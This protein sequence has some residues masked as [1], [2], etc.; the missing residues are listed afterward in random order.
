MHLQRGFR[1]DGDVAFVTLE[2]SSEMDQTF[3]IVEISLGIE[4]IMTNIT[5]KL[6]IAVSGFNVPLQINFPFKIFNDSSFIAV[7]ARV[8]GTSVHGLLVSDQ[9]DLLCCIVI[10]FITFKLGN[11]VMNCQNMAFQVALDA[12]D[13]PTILTGIH[14]LIGI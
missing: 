14:F 5:Q 3:V 12:E 1:R 8:E 2:Y 9:A 10:A 6:G 11:P 4:L 7:G 13:F